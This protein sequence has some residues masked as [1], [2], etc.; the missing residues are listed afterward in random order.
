MILYSKHTIKLRRDVFL[1]GDVHGNLRGLS[2]HVTDHTVPDSCD[3]ICLGDNAQTKPDRWEPAWESMNKKAAARDIRIFLIRGNHDEAAFYK[4]ENSLSNIIL[5]EDGDTLVYR[6]YFSKHTGI[7]VGGAVSVD[8]MTRWANNWYWCREET[9]PDIWGLLPNAD[10]VLSHTGIRPP[11][12]D[13]GHGGMDLSKLLEQDGDL[14][15]D[16]EDEQML[17]DRLLQDTRATKAFY[18]HF[19]MSSLFHYEA[20]DTECR[21]LDINEL[22]QLRPWKINRIDKILIW[23]RAIKIKIMSYLHGAK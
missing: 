13:Q 15:S 14:K 21:V 9:F 8:R 12:I 18:G 23:L 19:H 1:M 5:I 20:T 3:I 17:Y 22:Y 6:P 2:H 7:A 16:L 4:R 10:F 11:C